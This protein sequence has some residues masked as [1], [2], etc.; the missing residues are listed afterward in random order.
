[1]REEGTN[2]ERL[3]SLQQENPTK[4][5]NVVR[6]AWPQ[7]K[8][9]LDRGHT[10]KRIHERLLNDG[11]RISYGLFTVYVKRLRAQPQQPAS[12]VIRNPPPLEGSKRSAQAD[13]RASDTTESYDEHQDFNYSGFLKEGIPD[14]A[15]LTERID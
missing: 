2:L 9:A 8:A 14:F 7:I 3:T 6:L 4:L 11:I 10:L 5:I 15:K 1:M 12:A 13:R